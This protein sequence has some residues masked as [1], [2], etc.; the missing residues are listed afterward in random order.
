MAPCEGASQ[1]VVGARIDWTIAEDEP[2]TWLGHWLVNQVS[3]LACHK[4][5]IGQIGRA[6]E[7]VISSQDGI[8]A[9]ARY[10]RI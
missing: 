2:R 1:L 5:K 3:T 9:H 10:Q 7:G 4:R 8:M 6:R